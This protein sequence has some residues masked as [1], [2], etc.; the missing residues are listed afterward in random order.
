MYVRALIVFVAMM[1]LAGCDTSGY[2]LQIVECIRTVGRSGRSEN[3]CAGRS[4]RPSNRAN[5]GDRQYERQLRPGHVQRRE[6]RPGA[7][8]GGGG[9]KYDTFIAQLTRLGF[10]GPWHFAPHVVNARE[11]QTFLVVNRGGETHT[12][13]EVEEFG[14]GIVP[15]VERSGTRAGRRI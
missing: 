2:V 9:M 7:C 15:H 1:G 12:F 10:V 8:V 3:R 14:G 4:Y 6:I 13:T 5:Q 11:G